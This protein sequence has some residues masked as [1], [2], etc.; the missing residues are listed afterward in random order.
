M[1]MTIQPLASLEDAETTLSQAVPVGEHA[2]FN[3]PPAW[4]RVVAA[5]LLVQQLLRRTDQRLEVM[6]ATLHRRFGVEAAPGGEL[7]I[8]MQV[9]GWR[10]FVNAEP[11]HAGT[12]LFL[13]TDTGWMPGR[14]ESRYT[15]YAL[16]GRFFFTLAGVS[17]PVAVSLPLGARLAWP[18]DI[19]GRVMR[20]PQPSESLE[21]AEITLSRAVDVEEH[22]AFY[23]PP[24][25]ESVA[26]AGLRF[27][28]EL[29]CTE[30]RLEVMTA[31]LRR[32]IGV[33][34]VPG[35]E[36]C[37]AT[38]AGG[39]RHVVNEAPVLAGARVFLLTNTGWMP[40]RYESEYTDHDLEARFCFRIAGTSE[41]V[42]VSLPLG[43]Q[44][45]WPRDIEGR[46]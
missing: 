41:P 5:G 38:D 6:M 39:W 27:L 28:Q 20:P 21:D 16:E 2:T 8:A 14:Y 42:S 30:Q 3:P 35:G 23:P 44:L 4:E 40:G 11:V 33:E 37:L 25:R 13:L 24:A 19:E 12:R 10:H 17:E 9:G 22:D 31:T 15:E 26:A 1:T 36:L 29:R 45:A 7:D 32:R 43:A 34:R 18:S 46:F